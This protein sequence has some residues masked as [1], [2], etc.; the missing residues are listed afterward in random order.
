MF[1]S[2]DDHSR[3]KNK[4]KFGA[5]VIH[6]KI[7]DEK[8]WGDIRGIVEKFD[9]AR[10]RGVN[11]QANVYPYTRGSNNLKSII[12]PWAPEETR[13]TTRTLGEH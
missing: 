2:V 10:R 7:A 12:P 6:V 3:C 5:D 9:G 8:F 13:E 1:D 4:R 11:V